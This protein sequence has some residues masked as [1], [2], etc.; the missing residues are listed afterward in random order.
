MFSNELKSR[1][2][3]SSSNS[4]STG[5]C[6][7]GKTYIGKLLFE[8][9]RGGTFY[10]NSNGNPTYVSS[11]KLSNSGTLTGSSYVSSGSVNVSKLHTRGGTYYF[12]SPGNKTYTKNSNTSYSFNVPQLSRLY[13]FSDLYENATTINESVSI[14]NSSKKFLNLYSQYILSESS[15]MEFK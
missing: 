6:T 4:E 7:F 1:R 11:D 9:P 10:V 14:I 8:G 15:N 12:N 13:S 3:A 2:P 5:N